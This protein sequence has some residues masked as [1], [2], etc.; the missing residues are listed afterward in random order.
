MAASPSQQ[1][2]WLK[3]GVDLWLDQNSG[4]DPR[5]EQ[6]LQAFSAIPTL[7]CDALVTAC[8]HT[9]DRRKGG[10][11]EVELGIF[12]SGSKMTVCFGGFPSSW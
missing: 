2:H 12:L 5:L 10:R 7:L 11:A 3:L 9:A 4:V 1:T 6:D 8:A